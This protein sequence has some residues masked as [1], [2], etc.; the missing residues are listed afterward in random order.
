VAARRW[1][2]EKKREWPA[3]ADKDAGDGSRCPAR[4]HEVAAKLLHAVAEPSGGQ[5]R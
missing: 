1:G 5:E 3:L 2:E 4:A